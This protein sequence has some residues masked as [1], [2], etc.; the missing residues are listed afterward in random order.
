MVSMKEDLLLVTDVQN[1]YT[2]KQKWECLDTDGACRNII[3]IIESGKCDV[4]FTKFIADE[5]PHGVWKDYN[6]KYEDV[7]SSVFLNEMHPLLEPYE[8]K[9][10]SF[11]KGVY[12]SMKIPELRELCK[13]YRRVVVTGVVAECCVLSTVFE[14]IDLGVYTLYV[15]DAVS[16]LDRPKELATELILSGLSP[17]H[18][19]MLSTDEYLSE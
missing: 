8:K 10:G 6:V 2:A 11:T 9:Y 5:N 13:K 4:V 1:V 14:L 18:L 7:N 3:R 16:G 17:L 15:R 12:S 19:K